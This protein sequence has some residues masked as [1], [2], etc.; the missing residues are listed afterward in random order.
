MEKLTVRKKYTSIYMLFSPRSKVLMTR[1]LQT[2]SYDTSLFFTKEERRVMF[3]SVS[4][5]HSRQINYVWLQMNIN[6]YAEEINI[7]SPRMLHTFKHYL[8]KIIFYC[9]IFHFLHEDWKH[10]F[11][12]RYM[13]LRTVR[14]RRRK[15]STRLIQSPWECLR[16]CSVFFLISCAVFINFKCF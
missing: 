1:E 4:L 14:S 15:P 12:H 3:D 7:V 6:Q 16:Q 11:W 9:P 10:G 5:S 2:W 13:L 8:D